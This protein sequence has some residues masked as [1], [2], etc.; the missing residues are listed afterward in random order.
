MKNKRAGLLS[1]KINRNKNYPSIQKNF[2]EQFPKQKK[3]KNLSLTINNN[4]REKYNDSSPS[5]FIRSL[6]NNNIYPSLTKQNYGSMSTQ[7]FFSNGVNDSSKFSSFSRAYTQKGMIKSPSM[8][9]T[10][11]KIN[12]FFKIEDEKL[13]QEIYFLARDIKKKNKRLHLLGWENKEKDRIL[14]EKENEINYIINKKRFNTGNNDDNN[15]D[16]DKYFK[17]LDIKSN[18]DTDNMKFDYDLIFN[19][20]KL[21]NSTYNNL[22]KRIKY[23]IL[24]TFKEIKEKEKQ[25]HNKKKSMIYT[26][27]KELGID[28][29]LLQYQIQQINT[30]INNSMSVYNKNQT[31]L[32]E[33]KK[34]ERNIH[35]QRQ[36]M[37]KLNDDYNAMVLEEYNLNIGIKKMENT[38]EKNSIK[39]I[40]NNKLINI[41][42][43]KKQN[44]SKEKIFQELYNKQE[45]KN[46]INKL[47]KLINIYKFNFKVSSDKINDL[48]KEYNNYFDKKNQRN[49]HYI[50]KNNI[51]N[52]FDNNNITDPY[53]NLENLY[54][55]YNS[56]KNYENL[57]EDKLAKIKAKLEQIIKKYIN[58]N[59][60][61]NKQINK[62]IYDNTDE[63]ANEYISFG[64]SEDNPYFS[65]DEKNIPEKTNKFNDVQFGHFAYILFK[66]FESKNIL[67]NESQINIINPL[68]N[69][70]DKKNIKEIKYN[71][72]DFNFIVNELTKIIMNV[73]ENTNEK[74]KKLISIFI[75]ALFHNSNYDVTNLIYWLNILFSHTQNFSANE[76]AFINKLRTKYKDKLI[77]L[78]NK[79]YEYIVENNSNP[80]IHAYIPILKMK[81]IVDANNI[82]LK[83]EYLEFLCYYMKKINNPESNLDDLDFDLL[84]NIFSTESKNN[85]IVAT[86]TTNNNSMTEITNEEYE[87]HLSESIKLIKIELINSKISFDTFVKDI[88]YQTEVDGKEYNYFTIEN[89][90]DKL[91][92]CNIE[93]SELKLSC[94]CNKYSIPD[95]LKYIDKDKLE[96]D[97][98][99]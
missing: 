2:F 29:D 91:R 94:L 52:K 95:N 58:E 90:N 71:N 99:E 56:K 27:M 84:N 92:K 59:N 57:L 67:L 16:V 8:I 53:K 6:S 39:K 23:Q 45:K 1:A 18:I 69:A 97:I 89:F 65:S 61:E 86:T 76:E 64:I 25:I 98:I 66:N 63:E 14:T 38:L 46:Y 28:N 24:K 17:K 36:I 40:K 7:N 70:I 74:N 78:Y 22:F 77:L 73:L 51:I 87:R 79:I 49:I 96:K 5:K 13:S 10:K 81:E 80:D 43:N 48:K 21:S 47:K 31:E 12:R 85:E 4:N 19:N 42:T 9:N 68:I 82:E 32:K 37:N 72:D 41:L 75:G 60:I 54:Q 93:L 62:N 15:F 30:L 33:L 50:N 35:L 3:Y 44:L 55:I 88:T 83:E 26:K 11:R 34:L 20:K